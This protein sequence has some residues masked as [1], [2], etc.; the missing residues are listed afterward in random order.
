MI[1]NK[2]LRQNTE[3]QNSFLNRYKRLSAILVIHSHINI[4]FGIP[5]TILLAW[6]ANLMIGFSRKVQ[7]IVTGH[8]STRNQRVANK[9]TGGNGRHWRSR[10]LRTCLGI[11]CRS[12]QIA[13]ACGPRVPVGA[14]CSTGACTAPGAASSLSPAPRTRDPAHILYC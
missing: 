6:L 12:G 11:W 5:K 8:I 3:M 14:A 1:L 13:T 10:F 7:S 2:I 9:L 4:F